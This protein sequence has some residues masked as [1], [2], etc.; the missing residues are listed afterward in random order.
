MRMNP[1]LSLI[2]Y[3][4]VA[5]ASLWLSAGKKNFGSVVMLKGFTENP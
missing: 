2:P 5:K 3:H 4:M 1:F